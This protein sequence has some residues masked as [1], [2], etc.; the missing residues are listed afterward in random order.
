MRKLVA[1]G[2]SIGVLAALG[3]ARA[4]AERLPTTVTPEHYNLA[5]DVDLARARFE[6]AETIRVTL[7]EPAARIV[8]HAVEMRFT[9]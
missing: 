2:L 7:T 3:P 9:T 4:L 6:G 5:F 1:W 8:L